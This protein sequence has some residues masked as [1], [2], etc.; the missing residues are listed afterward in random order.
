MEK[1]IEIIWKEGFLHNDALLAPKL[2]DLYNQKSEHIVDKYKRMFRKNLKLIFIGSFIVLLLSY[3]VRLFPMGVLMFFMLQAMVIIDR[4]L[5]NGLE[6]IDANQNCYQYL[7]KIERWMKQK[8]IANIRMHR[9]VYPYTFMAITLGFWFVN[10]DG[11]RLGD[12]IVNT[13]IDIFPDIYL[14]FGIPLVGIIG[15]VAI[16][17]FLAFVGGRIYQWELDLIYGP[18]IKKI[19]ELIA[20]MEELSTN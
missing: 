13:L 5:L 7:K 4:K 10:I 17:C 2:I 20:D 15:I 19:E 3:F 14:I 16:V 11:E 9:I 12:I 8:T 1:S 6:E 18:V